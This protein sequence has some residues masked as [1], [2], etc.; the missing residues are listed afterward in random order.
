MFHGVNRLPFGINGSKTYDI[1]YFGSN[2]Q[3]FYENEVN[4]ILD[5]Y[6]FVF[7]TYINE[8]D[9]FNSNGHVR[10]ELHKACE[11]SPFILS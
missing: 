5:K 3:Q 4:K 1:V 2:I 8:K 7:I 10:I 11:I 6:V 9:M